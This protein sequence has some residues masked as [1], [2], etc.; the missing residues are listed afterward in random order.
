MIDSAAVVLAQLEIPPE[1]AAAAMRLG[2]ERGAITI[3][4]PAPY[5]PI[6]DGAWRNIDIVT[7]NET[8][9]H[10]ILG[11]PQD[12]PL[13]PEELAVRIAGTGVRSVV[14][15]SGA[16]ALMCGVRPSPGL[17]RAGRSTR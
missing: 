4:N 5:Q 13:P 8:E 2:R 10:L 17:S 16:E 14:L 7:P 6:E 3:L 1:T 9:A 15:P 12:E 11:L